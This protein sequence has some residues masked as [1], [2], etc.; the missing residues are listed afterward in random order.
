MVQ[1]LL[2][3]TLQRTTLDTVL[4]KYNM[5]FPFHP[6]VLKLGLKYADGTIKGANA[7]C[8]AMLDMLRQMV[9]DY[10]TPA[11]ILPL[12]QLCA[13]AS[14]SVLS[15]VPK[16][17][18]LLPPPP[19]STPSPRPQPIAPLLQPSCPPAP[20]PPPSAQELHAALCSFLECVPL[21]TPP[22]FPPPLL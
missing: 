19:P 3:V 4:A 18:A 22:P 2:F 16:H 13:P 12:C 20:P 14:A 5:E 10:S 17:Q 11:G 7:R 1:P 8:I 21:L 15:W 6:A 9:E